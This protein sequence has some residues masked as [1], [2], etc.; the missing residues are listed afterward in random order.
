M[1]RSNMNIYSRC[2]NFEMF[3]NLSS[4]LQ[5]VSTFRSTYLEHFLFLPSRFDKCRPEIRLLYAA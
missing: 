1:H 2:I 4:F 3:Y 5:R